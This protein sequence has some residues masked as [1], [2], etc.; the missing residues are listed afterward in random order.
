MGSDYCLKTIV[1]PLINIATECTS[2]SDLWWS[3]THT[4]HALQLSCIQPVTNYGMENNKT[5]PTVPN[6]PFFPVSMFPQ[7]VQNLICLTPQVTSMPV[8]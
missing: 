5:L 2:I 1:V 6:I 3:K 8:A 7:W 4:Q